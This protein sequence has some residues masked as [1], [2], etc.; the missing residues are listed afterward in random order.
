MKCYCFEISK[1]KTQCQ[2]QKKFSIGSSKFAMFSYPTRSG[3]N[4]FW[5][6]EQ[7]MLIIV[8]VD[9]FMEKD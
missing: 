3:V 9:V 6:K 4:I 7:K 1:S 2:Q 5:P 8:D